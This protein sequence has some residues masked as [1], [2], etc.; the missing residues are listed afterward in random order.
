MCANALQRSKWAKMK[1]GHHEHDQKQYVYLT[2]IKAG[3]D[4]HVV[5]VKE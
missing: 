2:G 3:E 5:S 1:L 4:Y